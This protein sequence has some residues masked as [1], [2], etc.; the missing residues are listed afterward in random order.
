[1][2][3]VA[4]TRPLPITDAAALVDVELPK[5]APGPRDLLVR[6]HALSV[7]PVDTKRRKDASKADDKPRVLAACKQR[8]GDRLT[9]VLMRFGHYGIAADASSEGV[10][11]AID[12]FDELLGFGANDFTRRPAATAT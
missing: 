10:D 7:N 3:A 11:I 2:K 5:P 6:V 12:R 9:T 1:M 8:L 4:H